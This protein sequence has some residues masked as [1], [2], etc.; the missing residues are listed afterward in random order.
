AFWTDQFVTHGLDEA[1]VILDIVRSGEFQALHATD[2]DFVNALY[3]H[4]L[5]R[6]PTAGELAS[7]TTGIAVSGRDAVAHAILFSTE[8]IQRVVGS[9][10]LYYLQRPAITNDLLA[11]GGSITTGSS[12][13]AVAEALLESVEFFNLAIAA[14]P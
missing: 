14:T 2:A 5:G 11:W 4:F 6:T 12:F 7:W 1:T 8:S 3:F 10:F 9:Y 13:D